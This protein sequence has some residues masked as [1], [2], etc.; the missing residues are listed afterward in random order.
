MKKLINYSIVILLF[1]AC[2]KNPDKVLPKKDGEWLYKSII[3]VF[4]YDTPTY[5][6]ASSG[7]M[8]FKKNDE[9]LVEETFTSNSNIQNSV[10]KKWEYDKKTNRIK[11]TDIYGF[12]DFEI[13]KMD[14][15]Y[16]VWSFSGK[17]NFEINGTND[18]EMI[19]YKD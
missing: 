18:I 7:K 10:N 14:R 17:S 12:T 3:K 11:I 8:T 6:I 16:Q 13:V 19:I 2:S 9:L 15:N 5:V 1:F 4:P